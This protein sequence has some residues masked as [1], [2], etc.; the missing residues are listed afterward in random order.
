MSDVVYTPPPAFYHKVDDIP[1]YIELKKKNDHI[2]NLA[3]TSVGT[4]AA[5]IVLGSIGKLPL[6]G[7]IGAIGGVFPIAAG[8]TALASVVSGS[9]LIY[10]AVF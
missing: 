8:L 4:G 7:V 3:V 6:K 10:N 2:H 5:S 1:E 9:M